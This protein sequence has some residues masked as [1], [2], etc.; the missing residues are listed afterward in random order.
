M[1]AGIT[2]GEIKVIKN[3]GFEMKSVHSSRVKDN[4]RVFPNNLNQILY[5]AEYQT[6]D[7]KD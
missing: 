7:H 6:Y 4:C 3:M 5:I 2:G 1:L